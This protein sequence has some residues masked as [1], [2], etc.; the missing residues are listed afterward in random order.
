M[1]DKNEIMKGGREKG[2]KYLNMNNQE[3]NFIQLNLK[4]AFAAAVELNLSLIHI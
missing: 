1:V 3:I 2:N 4:K